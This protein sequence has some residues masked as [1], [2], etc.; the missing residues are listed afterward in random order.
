[1]V[2]VLQQ[3]DHASFR[4][5][6]LH[7]FYR[8]HISLIEALTGF[9]FPIKHLDG[10]ILMV[11]SDLHVIYRPGD[12]KGIENEGMPRPRHPAERGFLFVELLVDFPQNG[13][14]VDLQRD[15]LKQALPRPAPAM[16]VDLAEAEDVKLV[17]VDIKQELNRQKHEGSSEAYNEDEEEQPHGP[18]CRSQ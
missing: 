9:H 14:L 1:M 11:K 6:G 12:I 5:E 18:Q 13:S 4:R 2:C 7:L 16:D 3:K 17:D 10:R 15:L 8:H